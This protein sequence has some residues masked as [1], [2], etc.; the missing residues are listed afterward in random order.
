MRSAWIIFVAA[1]AVSACEP[2]K[3]T[4]P[5]KIEPAPAVTLPL[6]PAAMTPAATPADCP[7]ADDKPTVQKASTAPRKRRQV[8][9]VATAPTVSDNEYARPPTYYAGP[10]RVTE[11]T[12]GDDRMAQAYASRDQYGYLNWPGKT[13]ARP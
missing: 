3:P 8:T 1:I 10:P 6:T 13:P 11:R 9:R 7:C 5:A 12:Y 4:A 2:Q